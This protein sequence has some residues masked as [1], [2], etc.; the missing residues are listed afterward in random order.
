MGRAVNQPCSV[1][2][3]HISEDSHDIPR[4][5]ERFVEI[6][7]GQECWYDKAEQR[8]QNGVVPTKYMKT[9]VKHIDFN[10]LTLG[11]LLLLEHNNAISFQVAHVHRFTARLNVRVF[12]HH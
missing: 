9:L 5:G 10:Q 7:I 1:Q 2:G 11:R 12:F 3:Q 8:H 4:V 6:V